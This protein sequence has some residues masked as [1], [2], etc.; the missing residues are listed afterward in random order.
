MILNKKTAICLSICLLF[1]NKQSLAS[2]PDDVDS[3]SLASALELASVVEKQQVES[4]KKKNAAANKI[5]RAFKAHQAKSKLA[6]LKKE[7]AAA[8]KAAA[9]DEAAKAAKDAADKKNKKSAKAKAGWEK[10]LKKLNDRDASLRLEQMKKDAEKTNEKRSFDKVNKIIADIKAEKEA[11]KKAKE[12]ATAKQIEYKKAADKRLTELYIL[13]TLDYDQAKEYS[14]LMYDFYNN[15]H[16]S[17]FNEGLQKM[18]EV[19]LNNSANKLNKYKLSSEE[20]VN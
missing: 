19:F 10:Y 13:D 20:I 7:K 18:R 3:N 1:F 2:V 16:I 8:D 11:Y 4:D 15:S 17:I 9:A 14:K 6:K 12:L 5:G